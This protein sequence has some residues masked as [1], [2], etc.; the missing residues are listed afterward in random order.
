MATKVIDFIQ[1]EQI[2]QLE[3][4]VNILKD[5]LN[6]LVAD[7]NQLAPKLAPI[8]SNLNTLASSIGNNYDPTDLTRHR[9]W[10]N[11]TPFHSGAISTDGVLKRLT[12]FDTYYTSHISKK[13]P[14]IVD[15]QGQTHVGYHTGHNTTSPAMEHAHPEG[16]QGQPGTC[17]TAT[18]TANTATGS[19][20]N[21]NVAFIPYSATTPTL[22]SNVTWEG[23]RI[24]QSYPT[25][26]ITMSGGAVVSSDFRLDAL[27]GNHGNSSY[28]FGWSVGQ[29]LMSMSGSF[30]TGSNP[31]YTGSSYHAVITSV[32]SQLEALPYDNSP[33][34]TTP[35]S[36]YRTPGEL[37]GVYGLPAPGAGGPPEPAPPAASLGAAETSTH[38]IMDPSNQLD[39][40]QYLTTVLNTGVVPSYL[41]QAQILF[42]SDENKIK[43]AKQLIRMTRNKLRDDSLWKTEN[44]SDGVLTADDFVT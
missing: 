44:V 19:G 6:L 17:L 8:I 15:V 13:F 41:N 18:V 20:T 11:N 12:D 37:P 22:P 4:D 21:S 43:R 5:K 26:E 24:W 7:I 25:A 38:N 2:V 34:G 16:W 31:A 28:G 36:G 30:N 23:L 33:G 40:Q 35:G 32:G 42:M 14:P 39:D 9:T 27:G 1:S 3:Q 29:W 10:R